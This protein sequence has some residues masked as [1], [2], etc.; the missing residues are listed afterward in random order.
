MKLAHT[1]SFCIIYVYII[2]DWMF[3]KFQQ[4]LYPH[5]HPLLT[6]LLHVCEVQCRRFQGR[7][8]IAIIL[9]KLWNAMQSFL[10]KLFILH[11]PPP[12]SH[13]IINIYIYIYTFWVF[14]AQLIFSDSK[15][16]FLQIHI[17]FHS[18]INSFLEL[19]KS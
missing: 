2:I 15:Y 19:L 9:A 3:G 13:Q 17:K 18:M 10:W 14:S 7:S 1:S 11:P 12:P 8:E 16:R 6:F 4:P 5:P